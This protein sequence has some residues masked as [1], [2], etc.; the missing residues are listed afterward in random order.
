M[1]CLYF[2]GPIE[3]QV[4][5]FITLAAEFAAQVQQL[6]KDVQQ[7][8]TSSAELKHTCSA[9]VKALKSKVIQS[10]RLMTTSEDS[11]ES[12]GRIIN[13][14]LQGFVG[15]SSTASKCHIYE[16]LSIKLLFWRGSEWVDDI[17]SYISSNLYLILLHSI[18]LYS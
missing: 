10:K 18:I 7:C 16:V 8:H 4:Q 9:I 17:P 12:S 14:T 6:N 15:E 11:D 1:V 3:D 2:R 5:L 13:A